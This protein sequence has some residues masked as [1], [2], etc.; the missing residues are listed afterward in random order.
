MPKED[1]PLF[2]IWS[3]VSIDSQAD[4]GTITYP[5]G[6]SV[7]GLLII[8]S[9]GYFSGHFMDMNRPPFTA[10]DP[11]GGTPEETKAAFDGYG[12]Y[13]GTFDI[14]EAK[15]AIIYH[16]KGA[17][18]PNFIG[19]DQVRYYRFEGNRMTIST[20]PMQFGGRTIVGHLTW[21]RLT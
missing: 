4:D 18:F 19:Q 20:A 6:T 9:R 14:D 8:D 10:N 12:G 1:S 17:W 2:G 16:A 5:Y 21:E 7:G 11:R 3:L 13:Y 15:E